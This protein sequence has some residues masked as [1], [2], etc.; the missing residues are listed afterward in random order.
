[1]GIMEKMNGNTTFAKAVQAFTLVVGLIA[2]DADPPEKDIDVKTKHSHEPVASS[3]YGAE[4]RSAQEAPQS[5]GRFG[6][7][8]AQG[9]FSSR[10]FALGTSSSA[11]NEVSAP[12]PQQPSGP[13]KSSGFSR[14]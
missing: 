10:D 6:S 5:Q 4:V 8:L 14:G 13:A 7:V 12:T 1:M 11:N 3:E 2:G 9:E